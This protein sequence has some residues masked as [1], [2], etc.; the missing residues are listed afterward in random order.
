MRRRVLGWFGLGLLLVGAL[1]WSRGGDFGPN[2]DAETEST[3]AVEA[4]R[5]APSPSAPTESAR[6]SG[7]L[8]VEVVDLAGSAITTASVRLAG[9]R[10]RNVQEVDGSGRAVFDD[11]PDDVLTVAVTAPGYAAT[12]LS[13]LPIHHAMSPPTERVV[14]APGVAL[15][16]RCVDAIGD[17]VVGAR[18]RGMVDMVGIWGGPSARV[19][20]TTCDAAGRF[21]MEGLP[22]GPIRIVRGLGDDAWVSVA[23]VVLPV[24]YEVLLVLE[25]P[26]RAVGRVTDAATG[27]PI[28]GALIEREFNGCYSSGVAPMGRTDAHGK[29]DV[30]HSVDTDR[31]DTGQLWVHAP[32]YASI[33]RSIYGVDAGGVAEV[34]FALTAGASLEVRITARGR[35]LAAANVSV[36]RELG[37]NYDDEQPLTGRSGADGVVRLDGLTPGPQ[38]VRVSYP[39]LEW[40]AGLERGVEPVAGEV[41]TVDVDLDFEPS[42]AAGRVLRPNGDPAAGA[43]VWTAATRGVTGADGTFRQQLE[44]SG[45]EVWAALPGFGAVSVDLEDEP[46]ATDVKLTLLALVEVSGVV[47]DADGAVPAGVRILADAW[48]GDTRAHPVDTDGRF[49]LRTDAAP[50]AFARVQAPGYAAAEIWVTADVNGVTP[51]VT[52]VLEREPRVIGRVVDGAGVPVIGARIRE[53]DAWGWC[54]VLGATDADGRFDVEALDTSLA[55]EAPGFRLTP[56]VGNGDTILANHDLRRGTVR[57]RDGTPAS[58]VRVVAGED[59]GGRGVVTDDSGEFVFVDLLETPTALTIHDA[60]G[61]SVAPIP[62]TVSVS[63]SDV[64]WEVEV[65]RGASIHGRL[66]DSAGRP[67]PRPSVTAYQRKGEGEGEEW[68][69]VAFVVPVGL[70][71]EFVLAGLAPGP[72]RL[73]AEAAAPHEGANVLLQVVAPTDVVVELRFPEVTATTGRLVDEAGA[74]MPDEIVQGEPQSESGDPGVEYEEV[75]A[76]TKTDGSFRLPTI[77]GVRYVLTIFSEDYLDVARGPEFGAGA[78]DLVFVALRGGVVRGVVVDGVGPPLADV[79]V[80][81]TS[82]STGSSARTD[83]EGK[84][85]LSGLPERVMARAF[86]LRLHLEHKLTGERRYESLHLAERR[87]DGVTEVRLQFAVD[88]RIRG[89]LI[90]SDTDVDGEISNRNFRLECDGDELHGESD[91]AGRFDIGGLVPGR[92]YRF[93][94]IDDRQYVRVQ[95]ATVQAGQTGLE[96]DVSR[97]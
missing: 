21:V 80:V 76:I 23:E 88:Q 22:A 73:R 84:F 28:A 93:T 57:Y 95:L 3:S 83:D 87:F 44:Y 89:R 61:Q 62:A 45:D 2:T 72:L 55:A 81:P 39:E 36:V 15:R 53:A 77:A 4:R 79:E 10:T 17:A 27:E 41:A 65:T 59:A 11:L 13:S 12:T 5:H 69:P 71:G 7:G 68:D 38:H 37:W 78:E 47:R 51:P 42:F 6:Q 48:T 86:G 33:V 82:G 90:A 24:D 26:P 66:T 54:V 67:V 8:R 58:G 16:G 52:V 56:I 60:L 29:F 1:L 9:D 85:V 63:A 25:A 49:R 46:D 75:M 70:R 19:G 40:S 32:G 91:D 97:R 18:L 30:H 34:D 20:D 31:Y 35:P 96:I 43:L 92:T 64:R 50:N 74:A 94:T 14:L